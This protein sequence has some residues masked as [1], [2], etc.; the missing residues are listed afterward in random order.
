MSRPITAVPIK[1]MDNK[2][3]HLVISEDVC[4]L[5]YCFTLVWKL[6]CQIKGWMVPAL[7]VGNQ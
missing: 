4:H 2:I 1:C 7:Y 3:T 6:F 5:M